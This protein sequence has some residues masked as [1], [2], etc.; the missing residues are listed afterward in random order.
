MNI[1]EETKDYRFYENDTGQKVF[2]MK[3]FHDF[4][5]FIRGLNEKSSRVWKQY[6]ITSMLSR[7]LNENRSKD[8]LVEYL[9]QS[10]SPVMRGM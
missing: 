4:H 2:E 1:L 6:P 10:V 8:F 3:N 5:I 9:D 7:R